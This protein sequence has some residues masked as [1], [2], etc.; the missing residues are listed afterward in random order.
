MNAM[1]PVRLRIVPILRTFFAW[2]TP[3][4]PIEIE[5]TRNTTARTRIKDFFIFSP[6]FSSQEWTVNT[7]SKTTRQVE[8]ARITSFPWLFC[9]LKYPPHD[10]A[11][12]VTEF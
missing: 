9:M 11:R 2:A 3:T 5:A 4:E 1:G 8:V 10:L 12:G 7:V 6:P